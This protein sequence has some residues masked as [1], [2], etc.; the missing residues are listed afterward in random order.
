MLKWYEEQGDE[1]D[2][3]I[4]S[5]IR[6]ARNIRKYPFSPKLTDEQAKEVVEQVNQALAG[7]EDGQGN[8]VTYDMDGFSEIEKLAMMERHILS[9]DMTSKKQMTGLILSENEASTVMVNTEDHVRIQT[10]A[11]GMN[12]EEAYEEA[13]QL[14]DVLDEKLGFAFDQKYGY[15]T[16]APTDVGTGLRASYMVFL[17]ALGGANKI[18]RLSDEVGKYGVSLRGT[19][20]EGT[21]GLAHIYQITNLKT[22]GSSEMDII[23][24]LSN[25]AGQIVKQERKRREYLL[26]N[27]YDEIED[28]VYRS[29]GVLKYTKQ[30]NSK[31]ALTLL[32]Q[33]KFG[34]DTNIIK[35][36]EPFNL[37]QM[38]IDTQPYGIQSR[39]GK[40]IGSKLRDKYRAEYINA[41]L[42]K[43]LS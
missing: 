40:Y 17:P 33:V 26:M 14:D 5:R 29:Y 34:I 30:I 15:L 42:P 18:N 2:V 27:N 3:V 32:A 22:L 37:Y 6:L 23:N 41:H 7:Y 43:L 35:F 12:L 36:E 4:S 10:L 9:T 38:M 31:D 28:Q 8:Y 39:N 1:Q 21:N 16:T 11:G 20:G 19:Y 13:N 24:N 25:I